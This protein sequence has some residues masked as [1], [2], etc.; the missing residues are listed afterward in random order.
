MTSIQLPA[1]AVRDMVAHAIIEGIDAATREK[2]LT[3][4]VTSILTSTGADRYGRTTPSPLAAAFE[5]AVQAA[6]HTEARRM[7]EESPEAQAAIKRAVGESIVALCEDNYDGLP[8]A[9]GATIG[10]WLRDIGVR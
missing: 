9:I 4:A 5:T 7:V 1:D 6:V 3:D 10:G 8:E 2:M